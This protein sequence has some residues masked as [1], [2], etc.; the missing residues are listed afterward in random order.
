VEASESPDTR[1]ANF[2]GVAVQYTSTGSGRRA[3]AFVHGWGCRKEFWRHSAGAFP[4]HRVVAIDL[5]GH[6]RSDKPRV[7][8]SLQY[9][10][11]SVAAVMLDADIEQVVLVGHSMGTNVVREFYRRHQQ[12]ARGLVLVDG[13]LLPSMQKD[14]EEEAN[15]LRRDFHGV[16]GAAIDGLAAGIE[17]EA[18]RH[19]VRT[20]M[21]TMPDYVGIAIAETWAL[22]D[23]WATDQIQ[24]PVLAILA[25]SSPWWPPDVEAIYRSLAPR[26]DFQMWNG[27]SHFLM[28]EEP[29]RFNAAL[30]GFI[31][32]GRLLA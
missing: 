6:G 32:P 27:V 20:T 23:V 13:S 26:L 7:Q 21:A 9:F 15:A 30:R 19:E 31:E 16:N 12:H 14:V 4:E 8:Y 18:L 3:L 5:P 2:D 29:E 1:V 17:D 25:S 11:D 10:A 22:P 28:M 24:V